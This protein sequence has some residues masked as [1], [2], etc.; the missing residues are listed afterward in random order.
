MNWT[1]L[2]Q[3]IAQEGLPLAEKLWQL[4]EQKAAP[5][6]TDWD[7]LKALSAA[8]ARERMNLALARAG[9]DP[10]SEQGQTF[11]ALAGSA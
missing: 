7:T 11:L 6:Q 1:I 10:R 4:W 2:A 8:N 3:I 9:I 5:T